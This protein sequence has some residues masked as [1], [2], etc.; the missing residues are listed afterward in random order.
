V[1]KN[2]NPLKFIG[3]MDIGGI[4]HDNAQPYIFY[5]DVSKEFFTLEQSTFP[6]TAGQV[7]HQP[8]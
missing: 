7:V 8:I 4:R 6:Q 5:D 1:F 3:Q 2:G